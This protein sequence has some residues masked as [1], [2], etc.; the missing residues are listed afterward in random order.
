MVSYTCQYTASFKAITFFIYASFDHL[1]CYIPP[2]C[3]FNCISK[4]S[5]IF[6]EMDS[7]RPDCINITNIIGQ[8]ILVKINFVWHYNLNSM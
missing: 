1:K 8:V 7:G 5:S 3:K 2:S 6:L 4:F